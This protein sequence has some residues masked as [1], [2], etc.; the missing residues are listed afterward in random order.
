MHK[1]YALDYYSAASSAKKFSNAIAPA[2]YEAWATYL[3]QITVLIKWT[4]CT[5]P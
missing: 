3:L 5:Q 4:H 2:R 1:K